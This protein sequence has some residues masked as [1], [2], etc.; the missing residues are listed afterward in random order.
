MVIFDQKMVI[1]YTI[2]P[3]YRH[4]K[5]F[6]QFWAKF[7]LKIEI[8]YTVASPHHRILGT[9]LTHVSKT[10]TQKFGNALFFH[11]DKWSYNM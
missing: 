11:G 5:V 2:A 10:V 9:A 6:K 7:S 1:F 3:P 4:P 8:F